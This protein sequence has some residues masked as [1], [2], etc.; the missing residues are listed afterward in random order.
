MLTIVFLKSLVVIQFNS[1]TKIRL[2]ANNYFF[3]DMF[4]GVSLTTI[5]IIPTK[6]P[7]NVNTSGCAY[8]FV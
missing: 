4:N 7:V 3:F 1:Y 2:H 8:Q 6:I 5:I